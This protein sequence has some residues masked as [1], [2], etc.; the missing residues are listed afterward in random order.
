MTEI[1]IELLKLY[2][3]K[4]IVGVDNNPKIVK[5]FSDIGFDWVKD[6]ETAWCSACLNF[7]CKKLGYERSGKLDAKSW[8][9]MPIQ[10]LKP[11]LGDIVVLQRGDKTSW[12]G[13]VGLYIA[14]DEKN[15]YVLGG[16]Q[17]NMVD[18]QPFSKDRVLGYRQVHKIVNN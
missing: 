13:H 10:I 7:I 6:D 17:S 4:E 2:G 9:K 8:L 5:M 16:N 3:I 12:Q 1:L 18:I 11:S 14:E 15:V